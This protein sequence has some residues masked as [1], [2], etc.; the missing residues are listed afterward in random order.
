MMRAKWVTVLSAAISALI[1]L[2]ACGGNTEVAEE[3]P[4]AVK[5][6]AVIGGIST[7]EHTVIAS[8][9][10]EDIFEDVYMEWYL[11]TMASVLGL[12]MSTDQDE[13]VV[14]L[15][16]NYKSTYLI[17]YAE[18]KVLQQESLKKG[19]TVE[20]QDVED[21]R[22]QLVAY[23]AG[24]DEANFQTI[25]TMW[26]FTDESLR[27]YLKEQIQ[28]QFLYE[29]IT[30]DIVAPEQTPEEYYTENQTEFYLDETR[31]VRHILVDEIAEAEGIIASLNDGADF[32]ALVNEKSLDEGSLADGGAIGPFDSNGTMV[33]GG[34]LVPEFAAASFALE[35]TGDFTQTPVESQFGYHVIVLDEIAP[36][37]VQSLEEV[38]EAL[39]YQLLMQAKEN[40]FNA[41]YQEVVDAAAITY[42]VEVPDFGTE[43][44][45]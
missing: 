5:P 31:L 30:K 37:R 34:S 24:G 40:R 23:Y 6:Q 35:S 15:I 7:G 16:E 27:S 43:P 19:L 3:E 12:D 18:N 10:G 44:T 9:N 41:Y 29:E 38:E 17:S 39:D 14:S 36:A 2:G 33:G 32:A 22:Q 26:G 28:I 42:N 25:L 8:V 11:Q 4:E 20:D 45:P 13:Q 21:Y 1:L